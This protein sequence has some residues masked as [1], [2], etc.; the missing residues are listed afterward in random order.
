MYRQGTPRPPTGSDA[1]TKRFPHLVVGELVLAYE[2]LDMATEPGFTLT[3]YVAGPGSP[4]DEGLRLLD[5]MGLDE[6]SAEIAIVGAR[7]PDAQ[8]RRSDL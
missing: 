6:A 5:C 1:P 4:S 8:E 7:H 2:G 3:L